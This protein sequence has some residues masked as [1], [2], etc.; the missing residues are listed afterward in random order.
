MGDTYIWLK[1]ELYKTD[2]EIK[3]MTVPELN[4]LLQRANEPIYKKEI[5]QRL[6]EQKVKN[7]RH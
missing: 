2:S 1:K 7:G 4:L 5:E 3:E 6:Y